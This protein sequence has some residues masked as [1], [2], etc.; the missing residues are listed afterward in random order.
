MQKD[1]QILQIDI[2]GTPQNWIPITK[3]ASMLLTEKVSWSAGIPIQFPIDNKR[4]IEVPP[5]IAT[6]GYPRIDQ[7]SIPPQLTRRNDR[8]F[9]RDKFIC[10][11]CGNKFHRLELSRDHIHPVSRGGEDSWMNAVT[12]CFTCNRYKRNRTPEEAGMALL[13][14]PYIPNRFEYILL[15]RGGKKIL[16]D[17]M[18][19]LTSRV[20]RN[21]RWKN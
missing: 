9:T 20:G 11:Y 14:V 6:R 21:S 7:A 15:E 4:V 2:Q 16:T 19:F 1:F 18:D 17:Q 13:Y 5:I 12:C 10:A 3:A 8:L